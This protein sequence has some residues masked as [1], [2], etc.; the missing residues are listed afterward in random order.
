MPKHDV[1]YEVSPNAVMHTVL[2][3][4]TFEFERRVDAEEYQ[5]NTEGTEAV[6]T[7]S[8]EEWFWVDRTTVLVE[9]W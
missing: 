3:V 9:E 6:Y 5:Q 8:R 1:E 4:E 2:L 7:D